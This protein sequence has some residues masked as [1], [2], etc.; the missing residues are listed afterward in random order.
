MN[1]VRLSL[2]VGCAE[3]EARVLVAGSAV[4][5]DETSVAENMRALREAL[6]GVAARA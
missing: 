6:A 4:L 2:L 5:N 1:A 3:A